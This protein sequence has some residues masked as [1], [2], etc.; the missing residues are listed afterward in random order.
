MAEQVDPNLAAR[1]AESVSTITT[2]V[3]RITPRTRPDDLR[4]V[5]EATGRN[6]RAP[7]VTEPFSEWVLSGT[8]PGG[9]PCWEDVGAIF[10]ED[11]EP[12][13]HRKLWLLNGAHSLLA[14]AGSALGHATVADAIAD[15]TCRSWVEQWW[16]EASP[17]LQ[18]DTQSDIESVVTYRAALVDRLSNPRIRHPL[19]QIAADGTQKLPARILPVLRRERTAGRVPR[20][21][22][23]VL[24]A[25]VNHL[26]GLGVPVE[27]PLAAQIVAL[28]GGPLADA[29][30]RLL[31]LLDPAVAADDDVVAAVTAHARRFARPSRS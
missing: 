5:A 30:P 26:R 6:D 27:D 20:S 10:T 13:E 17:H 28:R 3:D 31:E 19:G 11:V 4:V 24:G 23:R 7:V 15:D 21:A 14:Y 18:F 1:L 2:V 22:T 12:F 16:N 29:V 9:R 25:W 8:F